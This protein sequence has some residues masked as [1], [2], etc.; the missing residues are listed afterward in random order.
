MPYLRT[1]KHFS[2]VYNDSL[3]T[4]NEHA[5]SKIKLD[6]CYLLKYVKIIIFISNIKPIGHKKVKFILNL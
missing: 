3:I 1:N 2:I 5:D 4:I 6:R